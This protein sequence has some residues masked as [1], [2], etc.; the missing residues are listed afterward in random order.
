[1]PYKVS[2]RGG[3]FKVTTPNHPHGFSKKPMSKKKAGKQLAAI[4]MHTNESAIPAT[5]L[6]TRALEDLVNWTGKSPYELERTGKVKFFQN[7]ARFS[8]MYKTGYGSTVYDWDDASG[9]WTNDQSPQ[10]VPSVSKAFGQE[11]VPEGYTLDRVGES[12]RVTVPGGRMHEFVERRSAVKYANWR[13]MNEDRD[14]EL[15]I[16]SAGEEWKAFDDY[17][18]RADQAQD[19]ELRQIFLHARDEEI[20][21]LKDLESWISGHDIEIPQ[22]SQ[23]AGAET[24]APELELG[25]MTLVFGEGREDIPDE[26]ENEDLPD[27]EEEGEEYVKTAP[28]HAVQMGEPFE[29]ETI[30]GPMDGKEGDFLVKGHN[31][32]MWVVDQEMFHDTHEP[33]SHVQDVSPEGNEPKQSAPAMESVFRIGEAPIQN[34]PPPGSQPVRPTDWNQMGQMGQSLKKGLEAMKNAGQE[35]TPYKTPDG[36][37]LA[38]PKDAAPGRGPSKADPTKG[39]WT[40]MTGS[41]ESGT[42]TPFSN[43]APTTTMK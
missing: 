4:K 15:A 2:K 3:G 24:D 30:E 22:D 23:D 40:P 6:P 25:D 7:G 17:G 8:L 38:F 5:G 10:P 39:V 31:G 26:E 18:D 35:M 43:Q 13:A 20:E 12:Y 11:E 29:V 34:R 14:R 21:H 42:G 16:K 28:V 41:Q 1:M 32:D 37:Q 27:P 9:T 19:P 36:Q 33:V